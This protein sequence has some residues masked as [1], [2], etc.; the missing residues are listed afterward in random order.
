MAEKI[1]ENFFQI[2]YKGVKFGQR[3]VDDV[4]YIGVLN[5]R[6]P[7]NQ[8]GDVV[9]NKM[10][11][12][13]DTDGKVITDN[14]K[15]SGNL[16]I[17]NFLDAIHPQDADF[18]MDKSM[19]FGAAP[20]QFWAESGR[21]AGYEASGGTENV[22]RIFQNVMSETEVNPFSH[23]RY[24]D[25]INAVDEARG[26]FVKMHQTMTYLANIF[27][28]GQE[29]M[30]FE[31]KGIGDSGRAI[32]KVK[33]NAWN[34]SYIK[35]ADRVSEL[36]KDFLDMYKQAPERMLRD[37]EAFQWNI[38]FGE[39]GMFDIVRVDKEG[40]EHKTVHVLN[41]I[42]NA[43]DAI[44]AGLIRPINKYLR[45]NRGTTIDQTNREIKATL[46]DYYNG[47]RELTWSFPDP[48]SKNYKYFKRDFGPDIR[49]EN[50]LEAAR[51]YFGISL[52]P[53]DVAMRGL[54]EIRN[55][56]TAKYPANEKFA[57]DL[58]S[59]FN[60][61]NIPEGWGS[62][63]NTGVLNRFVQRAFSELVT[64]EAKAIQV[65]DIA[66]QISGLDYKIYD[67]EQFARK[68]VELNPNY[69]KLVDKRN[70]M[71][72]FKLKLE[73]SLSYM[74]NAPEDRITLRNPGFSKPGVYINTTTSPV[75][76]I[77]G[78][79]Y[80][81]KEVIQPGKRNDGIIGP[82]DKL[83]LNGRR[84][85]VVRGDDHLALEATYNMFHG[86]YMYYDKETGNH[87]RINSAENSAITSLYRKMTQKVRDAYDKVEERDRVSLEEYAI[88]KMSIILDTLGDDF[89]LGNR[90]YTEAFIAKMITPSDVR[91]VTAITPVKGSMGNRA[92]FGPKLIENSYSKAAFQMLAQ[93]ANG[94][95]VMAPMDKNTA[96]GI[97]KNIIDLKKF[98]IADMMNPS[99]DLNMDL[100][101]SYTKP[102]D[103]KFGHMT[104]ES[105]INQSIF[106]VLR[107][108]NE[109]QK[110]A[111]QV[112]IDYMSGDK[113]IDST[114]LYRAS[115]ALVAKNIP[116]DR[117]FIR[118]SYDRDYG[119]EKVMSVH[120]RMKNR[121]FRD[122][123]SIE[124][125]V[126]KTM[127]RK[128]RC[129]TE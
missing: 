26:R 49:M 59:F 126:S 114:T 22:S 92:V 1:F 81:I 52:N 76:V 55:S 82:E 28:D 51:N 35:T 67:M 15:Y 66:S 79:K 128:F 11:V 3:D 30:T 99:I 119:E 91:N 31:H 17:I 100:T 60:E 86:E 46:D 65:E 42:P 118:K 94:T 88:E 40:K 12:F 41:S 8:I 129:Y 25:M 108:G 5:S 34:E 89:L 63:T 112:I 13:R 48:Q 109:N 106:K 71:I 95:N 127:K 56:H 23:S 87:R 61:G 50:G 74:K 64:D 57:H 113:L 20:Y 18:D 44:V 54:H 107:T 69:N 43:R 6:Q 93:I 47:Y 102:V 7:R 72:E 68:D 10:H 96:A 104:N 45:Y 21:L 101:R 73:E 80:K 120:D 4:N 58:V 77:D 24:K 29:V 78:Y 37:P 32:Y 115:R 124:E 33:V 75:V 27:R 110:R 98:G 70:T 83:V 2:S 84:F 62:L 9:I 39:N 105:Y 116:V 117:Q 14:G 123:A 53:F 103:F 111:A 90:A 38:L 121:K 36:V 85:E 125:A 122:S 16:S 19:M 97:L